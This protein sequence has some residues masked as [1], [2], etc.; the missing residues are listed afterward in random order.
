MYPLIYVLSSSFSCGQAVS[1]GKVLLWP[2][3]F[4][5]T[6][7]KI[8]FSY[9]LVWVGYFNTIVIT[10]VA[11]AINMVLTICAAYSLSR[12]DFIGRNFY[13]TLFMIT[14]FFSGGMIPNYILM[15]NL[16][17]TNTRW[18]VILSGAISVTN[19]IIMRTYFVNSIPSELFEAARIDGITDWGYLFR[20]VLPLSKAIMAVVL[21]YYAVAHWNSYFNAMLY[22]PDR[23][24][25][26]LQI[27]LRD[28]LNASKVDLSQI[29]DAEML[30]QMTGAADLI[31][32]SLIVVSA[33]PI[34]C[35]YPFVQKY[36][37]K[38]VM[39]GSVKG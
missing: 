30:A 28:L 33:A 23:N 31:K 24:L 32:F 38:G 36:F 22:I 26:P 9:K 4:S 1:S 29:Q 25:Y 15:S 5:F 17:L 14:M 11:T 13:M 10:V 27:V 3:D 6:G 35:A 21:L 39:I 18:S 19:M 12:K 8:I 7:Y 16:H 2:V 34:L 37:E 20:I